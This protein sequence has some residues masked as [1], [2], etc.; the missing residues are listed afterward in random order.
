MTLPHIVR[1][2]TSGSKMIAEWD[3][4]VAQLF[5]DFADED[6]QRRSWFG[7][8]PE[9]SSSAEMC[10]W[11]E[12]IDLE[13]WLERRKPEIGFLLSSMI[14]DF[15]SEIVELPENTDDWTT[16]SSNG[17]IKLRLMASVIRDVL[18]KRMKE[19]SCA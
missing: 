10:C 3:T 16:F 6:L 12:D 4:K 7:I 11:L 17:W 18:G 2:Q 5:K 19:I 9:V 8:G 1:Y 13:G 15:I 14:S